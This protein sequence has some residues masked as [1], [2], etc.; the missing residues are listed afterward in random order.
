MAYTILRFAKQ[1]GN[2]A[3]A[4]QAHHEREKEKYKS[5]PDIK[6]E[7]SKHNIHLI[8]PTASYKKEVDTRI[9]KSGCR[10]RKDST[11]FV[12]T[13]ITASP[14]F[15]KGK[16]KSEMVDYFKHSLD[17]M[18]SKVREDCIFSAVIHLDEKT[19][20]MHLCFVPLTKDNRLSAKEILGN[21]AT[22]SKWQDEFHG[23]M[24][25]FYPEL[26][27]GISAQLTQKKH[28]PSYILKSAR[29]LEKMQV[30]IEQI[31]SNTNLFN[32]AK[33]TQKAISLIEGYIPM[34]ET[35]ETQLKML[36]KSFETEHDEKLYLSEQLNKRKKTSMDHM[37]KIVE[38][39]NQL[40]KLQKL[41]SQVPEEIR[42]EIE[43]R[44]RE[45]QK[46]VER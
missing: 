13:L 38:L 15:F 26:D 10:I 29:K 11:R 45:R 6:R 24:A 18:K 37:R 5:N 43:K 28:I 1:K 31:L 46:E 33:N 14:E 22:L 34:V 36:R 3:H 4:I 40:K 35:Y 20:H 30:E 8:T 25:K 41:Y 12:D 19:P 16:S 21:R 23:F 44:K 27:R 17:F 9:A 7:Y 42:T 2:P 39:E 32:S